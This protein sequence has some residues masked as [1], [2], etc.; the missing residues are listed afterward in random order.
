MMRFTFCIK[1]ANCSAA[2]QYPYIL[3]EEKNC[4]CSLDAPDTPGA[5]LQIQETA[6]V[7]DLRLNT[8]RENF[9]YKLPGLAKF[10]NSS[11]RKIRMMMIKKILHSWPSHRDIKEV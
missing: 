7:H 11:N 9:F 8:N 4:L 2:A 1:G 5:L 10:Q 6:G 3:E